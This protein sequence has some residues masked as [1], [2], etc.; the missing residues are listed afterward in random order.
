MAGTGGS[1]VVTVPGAINR[2]QVRFG[3]PI[4]V[5]D[6]V[7]GRKI[8]V[9]TLS[10]PLGDFTGVATNPIYVTGVGAF[11]LP[12]GAATEQKQCDILDAIID[13]ADQTEVQPVTIT[14]MP[15]P[16]GAAT[17]S[18][19]S[20]LLAELQLKADLGETQPVSIVT[21]GGLA[22]DA[23]LQAILA[24][25]QV[26]ADPTETQNVSIVSPASLPIDDTDIVQKLC[27]LLD[28]LELKADLSEI[29]PVKV[30]ASALPDDAATETTSLGILAE[31]QFDRTQIKMYDETDPLCIYAGEAVSGSV[32]SDPVW[33]IR[34]FILSGPFTDILR[35]AGGGFTVRWDDRAAL[36]YA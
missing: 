9:I 8:Q 6:D 10:D 28:E 11:P 18:T 2:S 15:L 21:P 29:Q 32:T 13:L 4:R 16:P 23:T 17:E 35:A 3:D 19:L 30:C 34:K 24:E 31:L 33:S 5:V 20:D 25:L 36:V 1:S 12:T 14:S 27:D 26:K 22:L 7:E